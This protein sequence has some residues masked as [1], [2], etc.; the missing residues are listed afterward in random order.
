[1]PL[2]E[3]M[4]DLALSTSAAITPVEGESAEAIAEQEGVAALLRY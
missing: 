2:L 1:M 4:I 3:R